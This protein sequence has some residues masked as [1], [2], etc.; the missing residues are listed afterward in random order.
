MKKYGIFLALGLLLL[1]CKEGGKE[2]T[3]Y[4]KNP[5]VSKSDEV[6]KQNPG[7]RIM[8]QECYICH[9]PKASQES[10]IAPPLIV[11]KRYY[12]GENTTKDQFTEDLIKWV[13]DPEQES[14]MP[15]ALFEF[16]S[17]PYI[18]YPVDV[19]AQIADYIYDYDI[20]R[21]KWYDEALKKGDG[22][23]I[24]INRSIIS[25]EIQNKNASIGMAHA[26]AAKKALGKNLVQAISEEGTIGAIEFCNTKAIALTD[27]I[28]V[29]NNAV[30]RRVS[31]KTRNPKNAANEEELGYIT[32]FKKLVA[33][34]K[35]PKPVVIRDNGEVNFYYPIVTNALCL[36]C[37]GKPQEQ[38]LPETLATLKSL[39]PND[40]A[41][42]YGDNQ[43]RGV[44]SINFEAE[45]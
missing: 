36:Q 12:I 20:E 14:K 10:M 22:K 26:M 40:Q 19:I 5:A 24:M 27:S 13:N 41:T 18:P 30:I 29:M 34:G 31:D 9:N 16:G 23:G 28:S 2:K 4:M 25:E 17:M 32:Y 33:T 43:V 8:E 6:A 3:G 39:Y 45:Y 38:V 21:P 44:W 7:K 35:E 11:V 42:G 37:H 15:D 1:N